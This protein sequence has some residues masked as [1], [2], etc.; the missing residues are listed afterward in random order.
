M[1]FRIQIRVAAIVMFLA[2]ALGAMGAHMLKD[3][4]AETGHLAEWKTAAL[5]HM[6][7]GLAMFVV[8]AVGK[9]ARA[10]FC[11]WAWLVG[12][13]LFS[14]SL[15]ILSYT[16]LTALPIVLATP[17]GGISFMVGWGALACKPDRIISGNE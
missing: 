3:R 1:N 4:L 14:G 16:G 8:A 9:Q 12:I 5:Y 7:H 6:I 11:F 13:F 10:A 17:L 2:I 15:Y